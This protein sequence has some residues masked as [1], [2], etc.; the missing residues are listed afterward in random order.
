MKHLGKDL[1]FQGY[2]DN[3]YPLIIFHSRMYK[4]KRGVYEEIG[5]R[6]NKKKEKKGN[7]QGRGANELGDSNRNQR[8]HGS[9]G[10]SF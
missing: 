4:K 3:N 1:K 8:F 5:R 6:P 10:C 7:S 9:L 2:S